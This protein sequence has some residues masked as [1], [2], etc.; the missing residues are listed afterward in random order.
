MG[1]QRKVRCW[2]ETLGE[3]RREGE[4]GEW[5]ERD[6][7]ERDGYGRLRD[8]GERKEGRKG[9]RGIRE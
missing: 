7:R 3:T 1:G 4:G 9:G 8:G 2:K 6:G 5:R